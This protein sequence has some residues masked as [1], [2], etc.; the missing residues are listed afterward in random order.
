[1]VQRFGERRYFVRCET[2]Q[3]ADA[4]V[5]MTARAMG[6][7]PG[8]HLQERL[9]AELGRER[10]LLVLDNLETPWWADEE[11]TETFLEK[12]EALPSLALM[13]SIRGQKRPLHPAWREP[14]SLKPLTEKDAK[15]VFLATAGK[16]FA[17]DPLLNSLLEEVERVPLAIE[18]LAHASQ[19][20]PDLRGIWRSWQQKRT[21]LLRR[22]E[23]TSRLSSVEFSYELSIGSRKM[24][25]QARHLLCLLALL[26]DG[27]EREDLNALPEELEPFSAARTLREVGLAHD[28]G[29]RLRML[30]PLR[31]YVSRHHPPRASDLDALINHYVEMAT[32]LG[33]RVGREGGGEAS[34]QLADEVT[35]L[36]SMIERGLNHEDPLRAIEAARTLTG[37]ILRSGLGSPRIL[38]VARKA[39]HRVGNVLGEANCIWS[40]GNIALQRSEHEE[41]RKRYDEALPLFR[42]VGDDL[43]E[44]NC[45]KGLGDIAL[46]RSEH[47]EARKR[48]DEALPLFRRVGDVL[49][50]A[51]CIW[52]LGNIALRRSEHEEARKRYDEALPLFRRVGDILGEANCIKRLGDIALRR[53][54]YEEARKRYDEAL[55]L[56]RRVGSV[57]GE[58]NCIRSLGD[59][60]LR[61]SEHEEA[62]KRYDEALPLYRR[63]GSILGEA[64]CIA[65]LG[66]IALARSEHEEAR[67]RYDEALPLFRRVGSILGEANCIKGLGDIALARS[68]HEEARKRYDEAL[69]LYIRIAEPYSMG[70]TH[71][72]LA[73][74]TTSPAERLQHLLAARAAWAS[75]KRD[76]LLQELT[77]AF[78]EVT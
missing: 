10:T 53:S 54:E 46:R 58:A 66:D 65:G 71:R 7:P 40:L 2:S 8:P 6:V 13:A 3:T 62:R 55:P 73:Q 14:I 39:A 22:G 36:D 19:P 12:F 9:L 34:R 57:L 32:R 59:I 67:K 48:Y 16:S 56:F 24:T 77:D 70:M 23:G 30:A 11:G 1:V 41:A 47:E 45:I 60:A 37:F 42:R 33:S 35:N 50:E 4:L 72:K 27:L 17:R 52:S 64:N 5:A 75:I 21:A 26:P 15:Q 63:V 69:K 76:D 74:I 68:E 38:A 25:P 31:E 20:E 49:G 61:R 28:E 43:G 51:T 29:Q 78:G 18:L 44:A